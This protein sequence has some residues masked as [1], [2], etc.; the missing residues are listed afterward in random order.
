MHGMR[1]GHCVSTAFTP[2]Q[3]SAD[4]TLSTERVFRIFTSGLG[5]RTTN[6][7]I[8]SEVL[9]AVKLSK[10]FWASQH[11]TTTCRNAKP[12]SLDPILN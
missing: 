8:R 3:S 4:H 9:K 10:V 12:P 2:E 6:K 5:K 11:K 7:N 1:P